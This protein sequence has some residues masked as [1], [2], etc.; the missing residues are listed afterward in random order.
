MFSPKLVW[1]LF[2]RGMEVCMC[3]ERRARELGMWGVSW[4]LTKTKTLPKQYFLLHFFWIIQL[5]LSVCQPVISCYQIWLIRFH[6]TEV[7][8]KHPGKVLLT[9]ERKLATLA[10]HLAP[11]MVKWLIFTKV[12]QNQQDGKRAKNLF[13]LPV[14]KRLLFRSWEN[15]K[16]RTKHPPNGCNSHSHL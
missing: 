13:L 15:E 2:T 10:S 9:S 16:S 6:M 3:F 14:S 5:G 11:K 4:V 8:T 1:V 7:G 12:N